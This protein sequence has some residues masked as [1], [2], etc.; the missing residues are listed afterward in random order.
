MAA[1][2]TELPAETTWQIRSLLFPQLSRS[3]NEAPPLVLSLVSIPVSHVAKVTARVALAVNVRDI[4]PPADTASDALLSHRIVAACAGGRVGGRVG[5]RV[6]GGR[7]G[8]EVV[9]D[10]V[11]GSEVLGD[12]VVGSEVLGSVV[13]GDRVVGSDDLGAA[14]GCADVVTE[15]AAVGAV[16]N[17]VCVGGA[18][19]W[20]PVL[21]AAA[22]HVN[23]TARMMAGEVGSILPELS[24]QARG[25]DIDGGGGQT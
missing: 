5:S 2:D 8:D 17:G 6:A 23:T 11:V 20:A 9:G 3:R 10:P 22:K 7:V 16:L 25:I 15:G 24:L 14:V 21:S 19:T 1:T 12:R 13:V 18:V 4:L